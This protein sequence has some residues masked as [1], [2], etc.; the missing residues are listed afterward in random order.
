MK[1]LRF[2]KMIYLSSVLICLIFGMNRNQE[3][4][5]AD[6]VRVSPVMDNT[7]YEDAGGNISNSRGA[8]MFSGKSAAGLIRRA[9]INFQLIEFVP[10]CSK[11]LSVTL[12]LHASGSGT[13]AGKTIQLRKLNNYCGEG[14]SDAP[15]NEENG[16]A[17]TNYDGTWKHRYYNTDYWTAPGG[18]YS[19][20]VS[21]A[22]V[23]SGNGY[24]TWSSA[25]MVTDAEGWLADPSTAWG[26]I[27]TGD[28]SS[29]NSF[30]RFST[31]E[32]D[33]AAFIPEVIITY[34]PLI[35]LYLVSRIEGFWDGINMADDSMKVYLRN[36]FPPYS[37]ED[38]LTKVTGLYGAIYCF[39]NAPTGNYYIVADHRNSIE[40]WSSLPVLL[41]T[42]N[43]DYYDF[44][45]FAAKAYG[46]NTVQKFGAF[47][48][49]SGDVNKD[50][51][52]D[53]TDV[54]KVDNDSY[55][56]VSGYVIT[57][58]TGDDFVDA[59]DVSIVDNN[60]YN[61]VSVVTP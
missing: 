37:K 38:S 53:A 10:P 5:A 51:T 45:D 33:T 46:N 13:N 54:S 27:L 41:T 40:T 4:K 42:G 14:S 9:V 6:T 21:A 32:S 58:V 57:D 28:E 17:S 19:S 3:L 2:K 20:T 18:D 61:S 31:K 59:Q 22:A 56:S 7:L 8:Y 24:Y 47:C 30:K 44:T 34:K 15:G 16:T 11:I 1:N 55:N 26:W 29:A 52:V 35:N 36:S 48:F 39:K 25:Q 49:Y 23:V 12:R 50:G 60:S 43:G